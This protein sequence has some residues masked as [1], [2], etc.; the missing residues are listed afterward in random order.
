MRE[1]QP[2]SQQTQELLRQLRAGDSEAF[3]HLLARHQDYLQKL[4][5]LRLDPRLRSRVDAS[6]IVQEVHLEAL[7]RLPAYLER[8]ALPFRLW[9]RQIACDRTLKARRHHCGSARRALDREVM[10]PE[11]SSLILARRLLAD[12]STPS[13]H[14]NRQEL[15]QRLRQAVMQ[16]A[17]ADRE[18]VVM[19]HFEGLSNQEV[20]CLLGIDPAAASK[21][22]G[23][24]ILRLHRVLFEGGLTESQ[25]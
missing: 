20:A 2:D 9:L 13:Q 6:D 19:R 5:Q 18:V 8:P 22:H 24:A 4:V 21:R 12:G 11:E 23:R 14:L 17:P 15:A 3:A 25:L 1:V 16:L 10:L 7:G